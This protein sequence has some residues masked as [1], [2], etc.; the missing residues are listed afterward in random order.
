[1]N[2]F[3]WFSRRGAQAFK[4]EIVTLLRPILKLYY[5]L[6]LYLDTFHSQTSLSPAQ[7]KLFPQIL[8]CDSIQSV[9]QGSAVSALMFIP[10][11]F[12]DH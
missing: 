1:M 7:L 12:L 6:F 10:L 2:T 3:L 5:V 4:V 9:K 8:Y 11:D